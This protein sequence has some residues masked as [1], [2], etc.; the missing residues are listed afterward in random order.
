MLTVEVPT[1]PTVM[2][3]AWFAIVTASSNDALDARA[4][5]TVATDVSP[6][7]IIS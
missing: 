7:P 1:F 6:A 4:N 5:A 2:P 3:A